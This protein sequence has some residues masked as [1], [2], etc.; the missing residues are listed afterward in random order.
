[1]QRKRARIGVVGKGGYSKTL[2]LK[3]LFNS[4]KVRDLFGCELLLGLAGLHGLSL[5]SFTSLRN[6]LCRQIAMQT[7][8][9]LDRNMKGEDAKIWLNEKRQRKRFSPFLDDVWGEGKLRRMQ[10]AD[11]SNSKVI[12]SS[13]DDRALR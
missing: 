13:R 4:Q 1:M 8:V 2:L 10:L 9:D 3:R 11:H 7:K 5:K 12:V 6:E